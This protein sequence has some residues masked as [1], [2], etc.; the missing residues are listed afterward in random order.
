MQKFKYFIHVILSG[1]LC[2][3]FACNKSNEYAGTASKAKNQI[4]E[5]ICGLSS[6]ELQKRQETVIVSLQKKILETKELENGYAFKFTGTDEIL[7][8]L[9]EFIKTERQCCGFFIFGLSVSGDKSEVWLELSGP[10]GSKD[11]IK[12]ELAFI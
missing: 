1:S 11:F 2:F 10:E 6:P 8:E 12:E 9:N 3:V 5:L 7:D 4:T